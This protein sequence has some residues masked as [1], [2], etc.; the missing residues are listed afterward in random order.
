[1]WVSSAV[2]SAQVIPTPFFETRYNAR[3]DYKFNDHH[4]AYLSYSSQENNSLNDQSDGF[5][6]LSGGNFTKE[7]IC[8]AF[9]RLLSRSERLFI[10]PR[11]KTKETK[12]WVHRSSAPPL[13]PQMWPSRRP[14][15]CARCSWRV[16][17]VQPARWSWAAAE[18]TAP[19]RLQRLRP[20]HRQ[21]F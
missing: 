13:R 7:R 6:D 16:L 11:V 1:M 20:R 3:L 19:H 4:S 9:Y 18:A 5:G 14:I 8:I 21:R 15:V 17:S 10:S 12:Q 2:W